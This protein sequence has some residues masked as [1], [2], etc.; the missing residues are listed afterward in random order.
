MRSDV[1]CDV[2]CDRDMNHMRAGFFRKMMYTQE[3]QDKRDAERAA[4]A[5]ARQEARNKKT[6]KKRPKVVPRVRRKVKKDSMRGPEDNWKIEADSPAW[7]HLQRKC[8]RRRKC[9][10]RLERRLVPYS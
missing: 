7:S 1:D 5:N 9:F 6:A 3:G 8:L 4:K 10:R 2:N